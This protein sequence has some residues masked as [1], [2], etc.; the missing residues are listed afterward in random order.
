MTFYR[1]LYIN[2]PSQT[3]VTP[4][5]HPTKYNKTNNPTYNI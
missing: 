2:N 5:W 1:D 4:L 3:Y